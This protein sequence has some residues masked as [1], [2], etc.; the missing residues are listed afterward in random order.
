MTRLRTCVTLYILISNQKPLVKTNFEVVEMSAYYMILPS[1]ILPSILEDKNLF[2]E[3][4][5]SIRH[6]ENSTYS[7]DRIRNEA[8]AL[9]PSESAHNRYSSPKVSSQPKCSSSTTLLS[10]TLSSSASLPMANAENQPIEAYFT[11]TRDW[12]NLHEFCNSESDTQAVLLNY[13]LHLAPW[14]VCI[15]WMISEWSNFKSA[16]A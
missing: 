6:S 10:T 14:T 11:G 7:Q 3:N 5:R 4:C 8:A 15:A 1:M 2:L 12:N 13:F 16:L 9:S